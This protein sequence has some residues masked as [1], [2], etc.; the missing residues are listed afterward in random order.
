M[1]NYVAI[2]L[3]TFYSNKQT[4]QKIRLLGRTANDRDPLPECAM[5]KT[6]TAKMACR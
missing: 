1:V 2:V 5:L 4:S 6:V 3:R